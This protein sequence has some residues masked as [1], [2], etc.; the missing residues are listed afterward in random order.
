[1]RDYRNTSCCH[2]GSDGDCDWDQCPQTR[3]GEPMRS[4]RHCPLDLISP[5]THTPDGA[6]AAIAAIMARD[7]GPRH[8]R[9]K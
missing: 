3:D 1:M 8:K 5:E 7:P 4:G 9:S 6:C 2:S